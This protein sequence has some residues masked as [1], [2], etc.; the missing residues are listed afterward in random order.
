MAAGSIGPD[1][2][3]AAAVH[4][5]NGTLPQQF[6]LLFEETHAQSSDAE[7]QVQIY[8]SSKTH[9]QALEAVCACIWPSLP[10]TDIGSRYSV[11]GIRGVMQACLKCA[12]DELPKVLHE[13]HNIVMLTACSHHCDVHS[14]TLGPVHAKLAEPCFTP[15]ICML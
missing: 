15:A 6:Y 9:G 13:A 14:I 11:V 8:C 1:C 5:N 4:A 3:I 10:P 12:H 7:Q 2:A